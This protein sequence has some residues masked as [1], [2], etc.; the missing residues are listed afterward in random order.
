M[1]AGE[2]FQNVAR[3]AVR[4]LY[5]LAG[6]RMG[7]GRFECLVKTFRQATSLEIGFWDMGLTLDI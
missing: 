7:P 4:Y 2:E 6:S 5:E 1:Y 3:M